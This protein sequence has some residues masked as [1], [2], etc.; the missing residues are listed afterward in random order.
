LRERREDI[1]PLARHFAARACLPGEIV[2]FS[3][4]AVRSL[5]FYDWP[6]NIRELENAV[7]R[8]VALCDRLVR[9]EDLPERVREAAAARDA[10]PVAAHAHEETAQTVAAGEAPDVEAL[11]SLSELEGRHIARV[12]RHARQ[13]TGG[14]APARHRPHH[15]PAHD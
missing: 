9:P 1:M 10:E 3:R 11:V 13:Q 15:A 5:V 12:L 6:G 4:D 8:A 2:S 14:R 7:I